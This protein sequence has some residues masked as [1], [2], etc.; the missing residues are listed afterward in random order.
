[1]ASGCAIL[2]GDYAIRAGEVSDSMA[3]FGIVMFYIVM[4]AIWLAA[5]WFLF[6]TSGMPLFPTV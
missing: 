3:K 1:M 4:T 5:L 2:I 6:V